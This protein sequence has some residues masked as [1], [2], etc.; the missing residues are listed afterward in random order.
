M[1]FSKTHTFAL[2]TL[3]VYLTKAVAEQT[4]D[5]ITIRDTLATIGIPLEE[6]KKYAVEEHWPA[7]KQC[8]LGSS[9]VRLV[10]GSV[11]RK[12]ARGVEE[13]WDF[14]GQ[15]WEIN[16]DSSRSLVPSADGPPIMLT[17]RDDWKAIGVQ[18]G[19]SPYVGK[20]VVRSNLTPTFLRTLCR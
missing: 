7:G 5:Y 3:A 10:V 4:V 1:W 19:P 18:K 16:S 13:K 20:G 2:F 14:V 12:R 11:V 15:T 8:R 6:G 9:H 17:E